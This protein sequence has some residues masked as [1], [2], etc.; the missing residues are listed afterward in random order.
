MELHKESNQREQDRHRD[1]NSDRG[2]WN[3]IPRRW[4]S[5]G[6]DGT[7]GDEYGGGVGGVVSGEESKEPSLNL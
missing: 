7:D 6:D 5:A 2:S 3:K 4:Q 1:W